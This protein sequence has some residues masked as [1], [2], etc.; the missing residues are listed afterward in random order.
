MDRGLATEEYEEHSETGWPAEHNGI[1]VGDKLIRE[2]KYSRF[3]ASND[4]GHRHM[5][6]L[7]A[8]Y[9]FGQLT[10]A[11]EALFEAAINSMKL[12]GEASTGWSMGWKINLVYPK[13]NYRTS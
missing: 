12:R 6:H 9:P 10:P 2:W 4:K 13:G 7:M 1:K 8:L 3:Y 5:S 11:D